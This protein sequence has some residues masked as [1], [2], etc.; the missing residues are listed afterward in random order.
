MRLLKILSIRS[1]LVFLILLSSLPLLMLVMW[2][3]RNAELQALKLLSGNA[4]EI[5]RNFTAS[6]HLVDT[7]LVSTFD[8][9]ASDPALQNLCSVDAAALFR[10]EADRMKMLEDVLLVDASG[11]VVASL[12]DRPRKDL[13]K[14]F[15]DGGVPLGVFH[16]GNAFWVDGMD[17]KKRSI[18]PCV[19]YF[20]SDMTP[21]SRYAIVMLLKVDY[22]EDLAERFSPPGGWTLRVMDASGGF[23]LHYPPD[24]SGNGDEGE[25]SSAWEH[26]RADGDSGTFIAP[27]DAEYVF[28]Y[29]KAR[30]TPDSPPYAVTVV[31]FPSQYAVRNEN[32]YALRTL[33]LTAAFTILGL[34]LALGVGRVLL[35]VPIDKLV[36]AHRRFALG[37][38]TSRAD[39]RSGVREMLVLSKAFDEMASV[40]EVQDLKRRSETE[41]IK[42]Q[43]HKD[44]LTGTWNRRAGLLAL[45]RLMAEARGHRMLLAVFF[46]D[47]DFFKQINDEFGHNEGDKML[48]RVTLLLERHLRARDILCRYGGDEFLVILPGCTQDA[49]EDVWRRIEKEI[50]RIDGSGGVPY[51]FSLS[52]GLAIFDPVA[53]APLTLEQ[54]IAEADA[55]MYEEKSRH[56]AER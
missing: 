1:L 32:V 48:R 50:R 20:E 41:E 14:I 34:L 37:D 24:A 19:R 7:F 8:L 56:K 49:A 51:V 55:K 27:G 45:E 11:D 6:Q 52:H 36:H 23:L 17:G 31:S 42:E 44:Y 33:V 46:I 29:S 25:F 2:T 22:L 4:A 54:L 13:G 12:K 15:P 40:L 10:R 9:F 5:A 47:I 30:F 21:A 43:A 38:L 16:V 26:I 53:P 35:L 28:G 39:I 18:L 3:N